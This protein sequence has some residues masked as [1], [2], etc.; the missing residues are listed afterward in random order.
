MGPEGH[1]HKSGSIVGT[2]PTAQTTAYSATKAPIDTISV[3]LSRELGP[4]KIRVNSLDHGMVE[5]EGHQASGLNERAF[6]EQKDRKTL[7]GP[8]GQP[9]DIAPAATFLARDD[10]CWIAGQAVIAAGGKRMYTLR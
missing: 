8:I 2:M 7:L 3:S 9:D 10:A 6:R 5:T 4:R 1:N